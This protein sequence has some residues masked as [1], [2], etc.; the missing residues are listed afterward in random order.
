MCIEN[1]TH[2]GAVS[3]SAYVGGIIGEF[4]GDSKSN[5]IVKNCMNKGAVSGKGYVGGIVGK[6]SDILVSGCKNEGVVTGDYNENDR[7]NRAI[8]GVVGNVVSTAIENCENTAD[9]TAPQLSWVGGIAGRLHQGSSVNGCTNNGDIQGGD[10]TGGIVG[11]ADAYA[12]GYQVDGCANTGSVSGANAVG[13][14]VGHT[15]ASNRENANISVTDCTNSGA[16]SGDSAVGGIVGD[17][18]SSF[19]I[20][21]NNVQT[22]ATV[23]NCINTGSVPAGAGAIVGN[24]N[25]NNDQAGKVESNFWPESVGLNAVG[26]GAGSAGESSNEVNNNSSYDKDG[27]FNSPVVGNDGIEIPNLSG[28]CEEF[29]GGH[30][31]SEE[32]TIDVEATCT[33]PGSKS[34]HCTRCD[35][36][37]DVT[38]IQAIGHQT[39]LQKAKDATCTE[40]GYTGDKVCTVCGEVVEQG[41]VIAKLPHNFE[42]GKC[43]VCGAIDSTFKPVITAGANGE[44]QKDNKD[45]LSFTSNAAFGDFQKVQVDGK[46]LDASNY[47]VKE[48]STIVTLKAEYLG[49]LSAGTHTLAIV[50]ETGTATTEFTIK[51]ATDDESSQTPDADKDDTNTPQTG[52]DSNMAIWFALLFVS[53][54]AL[55]GAT[56]YSRKKKYSK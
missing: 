3:G 44:W 2:N 28:S 43:T 32:W 16:V 1:C 42:D 5:T 12:D 52:D 40:E 17:H 26:S 10:R 49:T 31:Y 45:G 34:R 24:N 8:G 20:G 39:E 13:G 19:A 7:E 11:Y 51:A 18:S 35:A 33:T 9:V 14:I 48:G 25:T 55:F 36:K 30:A 47:T 23:S 50:S 21:A 22:S 54:S 15:S 56:A 29:F 37:T 4:N 27:N 46:D 53:G 38:E 41:T 6:A